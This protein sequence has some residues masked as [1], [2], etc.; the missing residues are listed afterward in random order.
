MQE[1]GLIQIL[2]TRLE[3][4]SADSFW[5]HR[6]SGIR[7]ALFRLQGR[8]DEGQPVPN[9]ELRHLLDLGF[10]VLNHAAKEKIK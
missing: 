10:E 3:R 8:L 5:A 4:I 9:P 1:Q 2:L 7:G 6:A